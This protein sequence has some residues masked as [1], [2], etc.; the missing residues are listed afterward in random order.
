VT[1][2]SRRCEGASVCV[3]VLGGAGGGD[4][5]DVVEVVKHGLVAVDFLRANVNR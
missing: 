3:C 2:T 4:L 5:C 1:Q